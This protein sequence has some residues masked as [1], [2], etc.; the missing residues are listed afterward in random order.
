MTTQLIG[1]SEIA[2][3]STRDRTVR[4]WAERGLI[5]IED[6][7]D[8]SYNALSVKRALERIR[9][10]NDMVGNSK[11]MRDTGIA[12]D[13]HE[14][15]MLQNFVADAVNIC[16]KAREQGM[17]TDQSASNALKAARS[18]SVVMPKNFRGF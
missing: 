7:E 10:I 9:G 2:K 12:R 1:G 16:Q 17:P 14:R 11:G 5:C 15:T 13:N 6:S 18:K 3:L 4:V 8:N